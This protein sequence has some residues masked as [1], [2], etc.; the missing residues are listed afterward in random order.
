M[1][2]IHLDTNQLTFEK[3]HPKTWNSLKTEKNSLDIMKL[4]FSS[5]AEKKHVICK[6]DVRNLQIGIGWPKAFK[7]DCINSRMQHAT[8]GSFSNDDK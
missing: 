6:L 8:K 5:I 4:V 7:K 1:I 2:F 3:I